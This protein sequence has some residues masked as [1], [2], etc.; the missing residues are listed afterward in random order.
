MSTLTGAVRFHTISTGR[1]PFEVSNTGV[2]EPNEEIIRIDIDM[3]SI[4]RQLR[5]VN[6]EVHPD[7]AE[8]R[9]EYF[10]FME[11]VQ[12]VDDLLKKHA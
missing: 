12:L 9:K 8:L 6:D 7:P 3:I 4:A 10:P 11:P 5:I 2:R 1:G